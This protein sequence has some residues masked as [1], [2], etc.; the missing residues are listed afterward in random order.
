METDHYITYS[1]EETIELGKKFAE[2]LKPGD[3]IAI[4]GSL[5]SGKT[6]FIKGICK[7]FEVQEIVTSPTFTIINQ[8]TGKFG[9]EVLSIYHIDLYRI[10]AKNEFEEIGLLD[11]LADDRAI[12]VVEW[13]DKANGIFPDNIY[14]VKITS[15]N[16]NEN[17]RIFEIQMPLQA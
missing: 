14:R 3:I 13:A 7:F 15:S 11:C 5:G 16:V 10:K 4:E 12:K 17:E 1:E 9:D 6:E 8:Y 2:M